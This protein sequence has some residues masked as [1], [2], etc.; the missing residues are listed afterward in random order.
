MKRVIQTAT[1]AILISIMPLAAIAGTCQDDACVP[2]PTASVPEPSA[3]AL[4]AIGLAV[5]AVIKFR[6]RNK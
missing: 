5:A 3:F 2:P 1:G 6:N 4:M